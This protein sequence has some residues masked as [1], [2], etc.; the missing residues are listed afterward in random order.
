[1][2]I[3]TG[4]FHPACSHALHCPPSLIFPGSSKSNIE[5]QKFL[6]RKLPPLDGALRHGHHSSPKMVE[7]NAGS[8]RGGSRGSPRGGFSLPGSSWVGCIVYFSILVAVA[9]VGK[10]Q[11][12]PARCS[13]SISMVPF[14]ACTPLCIGMFPS[15]SSMR[16]LHLLISRLNCEFRIKYANTSTRCA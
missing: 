6:I 7:V 8:C 3:S 4:A 11:A 14:C 5:Q 2:L 1:M 10:F 12:H 13:P 9:V 15:P 16:L